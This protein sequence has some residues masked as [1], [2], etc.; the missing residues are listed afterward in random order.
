MALLA[1]V[2]PLANMQPQT[3]D[4]MQKMKL[5]HSRQICSI[6]AHVKDRGVA[7]A[8]I[9]CL[10]VGGENLTELREQNEVLQIYDRIKAETGWRVDF[11]HD[12]L[13]EKWGWKKPPNV[14][15]SS[16]IYASSAS[17]STSQTPTRPRPPPGIV[18]PLYAN[19]DFS[20]QNPPYQGTYVPP[21]HSN[22]IH[23]NAQL[24]GFPGIAAL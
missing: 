8:S 10:A 19:A 17:S 6:V 5:H 20:A 21:N 23:S 15:P 12:D 18:N 16:T 24:Y 3:A 7:S 22:I 9:R 1:S 11:I 14:S 13:K 2:H 4:D